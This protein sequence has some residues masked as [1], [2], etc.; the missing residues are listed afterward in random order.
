MKHSYVY[1]FQVWLTSVLIG[2][3]F[4]L[5]KFKPTI[6]TVLGYISSLGFIQYY[7]VA[8]L[9]GGF[10]SVPCVLFLWLCY[11]LLIKKDT[12]VWLIRVI[13]A[14]ISILCC[15]TIFIVM[16]LPDLK[17]LLVMVVAY[18]VPLIAGV[19][20]YK[21]ANESNLEINSKLNLP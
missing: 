14:L 8:V 16:S 15:V 6:A 10:C 5:F 18:A 13:L 7:F 12:P 17:N 11:T 1:P 3:L 19:F 20:F 9:I 21:V 2:P 4:L